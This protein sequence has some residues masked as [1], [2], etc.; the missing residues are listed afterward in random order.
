MTHKLE[1]K[2]ICGGVISREEL[3][4][5]DQ[6]ALA[7]RPELQELLAQNAAL[8]AG[9]ES[10]CPPPPERS[11]LL[12]AAFAAD[13]LAKEKVMIPSPI[14][15]LFA[16]KHPALRLALGGALLLSLVAFSLLLPRGFSQGP[17]APAWAT[18]EG[19]LLAFDFGNVDIASI[20]PVVDQLQAKVKAFKEAHNLPTGEPHRMSSII[21][22]EK[23]TVTQH[24]ASGQPA[25]APVEQDTKRVVVMVQLPDATLVDA[26]KQEL[27][28]IAGL[29][30]PQLTDATWFTEQGLPDPTQP[31][32]TVAL[33]LA[34]KDG[35]AQPH[36]FNFPETATQEQIQSEINNWL[37]QNRPEYNFT[38]KVELTGDKD[39]RKLRVE[40]QG[41]SQQDGGAAPDAGAGPAGAAGA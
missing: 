18:T 40:I 6:A 37:A 10:G 15:R 17:A 29:P 22:T 27:A 2:L 36:V 23:K 16:G 32:L 11:R 39:N 12:A 7:S 21:S 3:S 26:L 4:P 35:A 31:G 28:G 9:R 33:N 30:A 19:A 8:A 14:N 41:K 20:Q 25:G 38:V 34:D 1:D 5:A 13:N 24:S